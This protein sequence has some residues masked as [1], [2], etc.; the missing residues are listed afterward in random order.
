MKNFD[1]GLVLAIKQKNE[2]S[3]YSNVSKPRLMPL[4]DI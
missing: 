1:Q 2:D 4:W 3:L